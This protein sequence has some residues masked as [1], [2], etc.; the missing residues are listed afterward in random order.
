M[1]KTDQPA[2]AAP[3]TRRYERIAW[4]LLLVAFGMFCGLLFLGGQYT[5]RWLTREPAGVLRVQL[6]QPLAVQVQRSGLVKLEVLQGSDGELFAG[7]R[8]IVRREATAGPASTLRFGSAAITL[9]AGTDLRVGAWGKQWNDPAAAN[10]RLELSEGQILVELSDTY[11]TI[12]V[13]IDDKLGGHPVV[14]NSPGRYRVRVIDDTNPALALAERTGKRG[15]EV[16]TEVGVARVGAVDVMRGS[17]LLEIANGAA[18]EQRPELNRWNLLRDGSLQHLVD[19]LLGLPAERAWNRNSNATVEGAAD[20][21]LVQPKQDCVDPVERAECEEPAIR[22]VRMGGNT[23]GFVTAIRQN[24]D[25]DVAAYRQVHLQADIQIVHQSLSMAGESGT[26][27][28]MLVRV[29]YTNDVGENLET[30]YCYWAFTYPN[31]NGVESRLP[32]IQTQRIAPKTWHSVDIDLKEQIPNLV[33]IQEISIQANGH[34]YE[35][36]V[37]NVRLWGEGLAE[38]PTQ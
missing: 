12:E 22:L 31:Q 24:V 21:G 36:Q 8:I 14:L 10:A 27:C 7:D 13:D 37:R 19:E 34:D 28:P 23:K 5:Y 35:S 16:A 11:Q 30:N 32:Y 4:A 33:K 9:W 18:P 29:K 2:K 26:E 25:A 1:L 17:R 15:L 20:S 3:I 6:Q 38:L